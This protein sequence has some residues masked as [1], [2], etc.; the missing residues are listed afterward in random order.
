MTPDRA[1]LEISGEQHAMIATRQ[2]TA[3]GLSRAAVLKRARA[4]RLTPF[5]RG[6]SRRPRS[7]GRE[8]AC[9]PTAARW[10]GP[11]CA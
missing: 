9:A 2:L 5:I 11:G 6:V 10:A 3:L 4:G 7:A 8:R 1:I